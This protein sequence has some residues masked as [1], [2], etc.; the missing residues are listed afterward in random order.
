[1][2]LRV[3]IAGAGRFGALHARVWQETG[4]QIVGVVD[5]QR[6]RAVAFAHQRVAGTPVA[7]DSLSRVIDDTAPDVVVITSTEDTH[8]EL[9]LTALDKGCHIFVEKPFATSLAGARRVRRHAEAKDRRVV[10]GHISRFSPSIRR[11]VAML[12]EGRVGDLWMMRLRRDFSRTWFLDF[13]DRVHPAWESAIHDIDLA[14]C[15]ADSPAK[16]VSAISSRAAGDAAASV[17][18]A[19]IEFVSG[20][21]ATVETAWTLPDAAPENSLGAMPLAGTILAETE[22]HGSEGVIRVRYPDDGLSMWNPAG[23]HAPNVELWPEL[24]GEVGGAIRAEIDYAVGYFAG[25]ITADRVPL[26]QVEWGIE[27]AEAIV[28]SL[29]QRAAVELPHTTEAAVG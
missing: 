2:T 18:S 21:T 13:G 19:H 5:T 7:E 20:V 23:V 12:A 27:I 11:M 3:V 24:D 22:L 15:F 28:S 9:A 8:E 4:C 1:M 25:Q 14:L 26:H 17:V 10:T 6:D 16:R 29:E